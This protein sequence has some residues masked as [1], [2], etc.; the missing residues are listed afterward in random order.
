MPHSIPEQPPSAEVKMEEGTPDMDQFDDDD[1]DMADIATPPPAESSGEVQNGT[2]EPKE[3]NNE[4]LPP[5][6][7]APT[8]LEDLF[9]DMDSDDE[10]FPSSRPAAVKEPAS[11]PE[12]TPYVIRA[13]KVS[14]PILR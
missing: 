13:G 5:K 2:R 11:S 10:E 7:L 6:E 4:D 12:A 9:D 8:K 1:I 14:W 3:E